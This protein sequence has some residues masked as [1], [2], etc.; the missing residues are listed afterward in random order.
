MLYRNC[1]GGVVF[2]REQVLLLK[3][4]KGEWVLPKGIVPEGENSREVALARVRREAGVQARVLGIAGKTEYE[5]YS[6]TRKKPVCNQVL[7]YLMEA[8]ENHC[9]PNPREDFTDGGFYDKDDAL[10]R[11]SYTQDRTI[12]AES[13]RHI[14]AL[15]E[16]M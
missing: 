3:N 15:R 16:E 4:E 14:A 10:T 9:A 8:D 2:F 6:V 13:Y 7:W 12:L 11:V 1:A 5:F